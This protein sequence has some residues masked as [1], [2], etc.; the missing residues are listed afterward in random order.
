VDGP[1]SSKQ[2]PVVTGSHIII[3]LKKNWL[4][5]PHGI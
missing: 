3:H 4:N 2:L 1:S 5:H